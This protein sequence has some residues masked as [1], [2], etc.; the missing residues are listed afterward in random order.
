MYLYFEMRT[1]SYEEL[2]DLRKNGSLV[3]AGL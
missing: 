3:S 1:Y 2:T